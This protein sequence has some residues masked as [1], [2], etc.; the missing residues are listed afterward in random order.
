MPKLA[1]TYFDFDGGRSEPA[2]LALAIASL[3]FEDRPLCDDVMDA[4]EDVRT[5]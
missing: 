5:A 2:R 3:P 1:L 4:V